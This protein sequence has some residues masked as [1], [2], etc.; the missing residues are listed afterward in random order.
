MGK[1]ADSKT[2]KKESKKDKRE[3][4]RKENS[5]KDDEKYDKSGK[6]GKWKKGKSNHSYDTRE[7]KE[8]ACIL[9]ET[10][11]IIHHM[12]GDGNCMFRSI[13]DQITG[14]CDHHL[15]FREKIM[16]YIAE[17]ADHFSLFMEDDEKFDV[18]VERMSECNEWG[19]HQELYA[20]SQCL[21]TNITV[22]QLDNPTY[23]IQ[24]GENTS[25][26][27]NIKLSYHGD[28]HYNSVRADPSHVSTT[29]PPAQDTSFVFDDN[30]ALAQSAVPWMDRDKV[31][32]VLQQ[33]KGDVDAAIELLCAEPDATNNNETEVIVSAT[34]TVTSAAEIVASSSKMGTS[35]EVLAV[36][37]AALQISALSLSAGAANT[38]VTAITT[39]TST[40]V[41][42]P[43]ALDP[44][45]SSPPLPSSSAT[46]ASVEAPA[47]TSALTSTTG[48]T[49]EEIAKDK[50]YRKSGDKQGKPISKKVIVLLWH[51]CA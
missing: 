11:L 9:A 17:H 2:A 23:V 8:L 48:G 16:K 19:G 18:Y 51:T 47:A 39:A 36:T 13:A 27:K 4:D 30:L 41:V 29:A 40:V 33:C 15:I 34:V 14:D 3:A 12:E 28:C 6:N 26:T 5:K 7:E 10:G 35:K 49:P 50:K 43:S 1:K 31:V 20:A 44:A 45:P 24:A 25:K 38:I 32:Q 42:D 37:E 46:S 22:Y 21:N